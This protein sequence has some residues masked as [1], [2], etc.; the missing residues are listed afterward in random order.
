M[1]KLL[2]IMLCAITLMFCACGQSQNAP[3]TSD[4]GNV[5]QTEETEMSDS[6]EA[7]TEASTE[8]AATAANTSQP[9]PAETAASAEPATE[10]TAASAA[11]E[12]ETATSSGPVDWHNYLSGNTFDLT[13]YATALGYTWIPDPE[14]EGL[15][16]YAISRNG[17][18]YF[19]CYHSDIVSV[20]WEDKDGSCW[21]IGGVTCSGVNAYTIKSQGQNDIDTSEGMLATIVSGMYHLKTDDPLV[22]YL[23]FPEDK[24][25]YSLVK[26]AGQASYY[27]N[28]MIK[29]RNFGEIIESYAIQSWN[30]FNVLQTK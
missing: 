19:Y 13:A 30:N 18:R 7:A 27:P 1:K 4:T 23:I 20:Y 10:T 16:M 15:A 21:A 12:P 28:G 25:G 24:L 14:W 6:T 26:C 5:Y 9:A 2:S 29:Q 17:I 8:A 22:E 11:A 3:A